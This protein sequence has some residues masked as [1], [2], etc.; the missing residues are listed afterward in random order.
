M[1]L[2]TGGHRSK[3]LNAIPSIAACKRG[4]EYPEH[5]SRRIGRL[6]QRH[7]SC[8][9]KAQPPGGEMMMPPLN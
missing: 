6:D 4:H 9:E 2:G 7:S 5:R 1:T 3:I 8:K